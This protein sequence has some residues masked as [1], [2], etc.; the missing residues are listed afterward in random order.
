MPS[1]GHSRGATLTDLALAGRAAGSRSV[2]VPS[3]PSW[4]T[5]AAP[6]SPPWLPRT[7]AAS[8]RRAS[9]QASPR[10]WRRTLPCGA[11]PLP[12]HASCAAMAPA[13]RPSPSPLAARPRASPRRRARETSGPQGSPGPRR[14]A[15]C[16]AASP[17]EWSP[18]P[19]C[20]RRQPQS[21][22]DSCRRH[23]ARRKQRPAVRR[24][25]LR[26]R[27][28]PLRLL[29]S[30]PASPPLSRPPS[31]GSARQASRRPSWTRRHLRRVAAPSAPSAPRRK[32]PPWRAR[33]TS[34]P[35]CG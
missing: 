18:P 12:R 4:P 30:F 7:P 3:S 21:P 13:P 20:P 31:C 2:R 9:N 23:L 8:R 14:R 24:H 16:A 19:A 17:P 34:P 1:T 5:P 29:T 10:A 28:P 33:T 35:T 32:S 26:R 6:C 15:V 25:R 11:C 27:P 22:F